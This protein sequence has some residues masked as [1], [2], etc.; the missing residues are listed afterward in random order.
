MLAERDQLAR[1]TQ[2]I[3]REGAQRVLCAYASRHPQSARTRELIPRIIAAR[4]T[5]ERAESVLEWLAAAVSR[6]AESNPS[7]VASV[8]AALSASPE[9][10]ARFLKAQAASAEQAERWRNALE[11]PAESAD[12]FM[13]S[14]A[15]V[16]LLLRAY[17]ADCID[18]ALPDRG[19][20]WFR[21][22]VLAS[23][24]GASG[25]ISDPAILLAGGWTPG[26]ADPPVPPADWDALRN[27]VAS[28]VLRRF[29]RGL[30]GF[31]DSSEQH[32]RDNFLSGAGRVRVM[33]EQLTVWLPS[34]PLQLVLRIAGWHGREYETTW[35]AQRTVRIW[36]DGVDT[37]AGA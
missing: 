4:P 33:E 16:F 22:G 32:L 8:I 24:M 35:F 6:L 14:Y 23:C 5:G 20:A 26:E 30:I 17:E 28:R 34:V 13:S 19:R 27:H 25:T 2:V 21:T 31:S 10:I 18:E 15:A 7:E 9:Q 12:E 37:G 1:V 3:G 36:L 29:A 11:R